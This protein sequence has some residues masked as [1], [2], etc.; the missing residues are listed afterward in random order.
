MDLTL[1]K[2]QAA[3]M[4]YA[5]KS[6]AEVDA[7]VKSNGVSVQQLKALPKVKPMT[8]AEALSALKDPKLLDY[9]AMK[10]APTQGMSKP[11]LYA[12]GAGKAVVDKA[13]G[14]GQM[15]GL[16]SPQDVQES[17]K[18]DAPL[19]R[20]PEG[21]TGNTAA[22]MG[23]ASLIPYRNLYTAMAAGTGEGLLTPTAPGDSRIKNAAI[24]SMLGPVGYGIAKGAG[25]LLAGKVDP[26]NVTMNDVTRNASVDFLNKNN[27]P[28]SY[29]ETTGAPWAK[30]LE[31]MFS[32]LPGSSGQ[33]LGI[34]DK[35]QLGLNSVI[36]NLTDGPVGPQ[37]DKFGA[38]K[39]ITF[40]KQFFDDLA[41]IKGKYGNVAQVDLPNSALKATDSYMGLKTPNPA[42]EGF[43]PKFRAAAVAQGVPENINVKD[44]IFKEGQ[45]IP[46]SGERGDFN[47]LASLRSLYSKRAWDAT[48]PVDQSA[49]KAMVNAFDDLVTRSYPKEAKQ[50][51]DLRSKYAVERSL[52]P[53]LDERGNYSLPK[54]AS[55]V[56]KKDA[57]AKGLLD[58]LTG[59]KGETLRNLAAAEPFI[60]PGQSSGTAENMLWQKLATGGLLAGGAGAGYLLGG[61]PASAAKGGAAMAGGLFAAPYLLNK[62]LQSRLTGSPEFERMLIQLMTTP[63]IGYS[64]QE[65]R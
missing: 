50:Y 51:A 48:D 37:L 46:F 43:D 39:T 13:R 15:V 41:A 56:Q 22:E 36:H 14:A 33:M 31:R 24:G 11:E 8:H 9:E 17:R 20:T 18:L 59:D 4:M 61:D 60:K 5:G 47:N 6:E 53:A 62:T 29:A 58:N 35:Q 63:A 32:N 64:G 45:T 10:Y 55:I 49:Y 26:S 2:R 38:G 12:S 65:K 1:I 34:K 7:F 28:P 52:A 30:S 27:I 25:H 54:I 40:D 44:P 21:Q 16:V 23:M 57:D 19:M 42:L 3:A